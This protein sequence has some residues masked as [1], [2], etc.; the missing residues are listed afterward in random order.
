[1]NKITTTKKYKQFL[2]DYFKGLAIKSSLFFNWDNGLRFDLQKGEVGTDEYFGE[3]HKRS[4]ALFEAAFNIDDDLF[5]VIMDH[6]YKRAKIRLGNY[7]FKQIGDLDCR[8]I[9]YQKIH[10]LYDRKDRYDIRNIAI[11][12]S[13]T[14]KLK[15]KNILKATGNTD[16]SERQPRL[17]KNGVFTSKEI[18]FINIDKKIIF[19][20]YDDRGLDI[21]AHDLEQLRPIYNKFNDWL[22]EI[23]KEKIDGLF[24]TN[25]ESNHYQKTL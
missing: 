17:D 9:G 12:E 1:M 15:Y 10:K 20:M 16:F 4:V 18:Y 11:V 8:H 23:N 24:N 2:N 3:V 19:H 7:C 14:E 22:L 21:V 5:I 13:I 6:R 25:K